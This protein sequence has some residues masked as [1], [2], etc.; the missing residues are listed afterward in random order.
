VINWVVRSA[1]RFVLCG[2][3]IVGVSN[4]GEGVSSNAFTGGN[5]VSIRQ[6]R[7][8][9]KTLETSI[10]VELK[11]DG[12]GAGKFDT[13]VPFLEHMLDQIARHGL[14]DLDVHCKGDVHIDDH[15]S[16]EDIGITLGQAFADA[17]GDRKGINRT[18]W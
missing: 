4:Y 15:H 13:G 14:F 2:K 18:C 10:A 16:V 1:R 8:E 6:A 5:C 11:L 9:R 7:V 17:L 12:S 3:G